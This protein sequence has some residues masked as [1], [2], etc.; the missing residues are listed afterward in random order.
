LPR[1][2]G[3]ARALGPGIVWLALAQGSG[4]LI[5]WPYVV[6]RYGLAFLF[7]LI[8]ACLV[9]WPVNYAIGRY[10][11]LT[12]ESIMRGFL[13]LDRRLGIV[14]Y[15]LMT[16]SF[17]WVGSFAAAGG[18]ALASLV[19]WPA[20]WGAKARTDLWALV[21]MALL[22]GSFLLS[23]AFY[24][25]IEWFMAAVSIVTL[26][27]LLLAC[28]HPSVLA[29]L[30]AFLRG[31]VR[32]DLPPPRPWDPG[33]ATRLLTAIT[34]A[35]LGG[36]WTLFYSYWL[37]AKGA[38]MA[39][40]HEAAAPAA[41]T[42][43]SAAQE[44]PLLPEGAMSD[45]PLWKRYLLCDSGIGVVGN[46]ATTLMTCLLAYALLFP[47]GLYPDGYRLAVVQSE[48]FAVRFGGLGR[49]LFLVVAAAFLCDTWIG[50]MDTMSR[51]H[52]DAVRA[53]VPRL[54]A[55]PARRLYY[56]FLGVGSALTVVTLPLAEPGRLIL[57]TAVI[58]FIGTVIYTWALVPL[59]GS[60][61][62]RVAPHLGP[63]RWYS[64]LALIVAAS[65]YTLL[66][67]L[68]LAALLRRG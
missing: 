53:L 4:E 42:G 56:L 33:D 31:L 8:P 7:L 30:P 35:G 62:A 6:A 3:Y 13:R 26:L 10:T 24:R 40:H 5:W 28:A 41:D 16:V 47:R 25:F 29:A 17:L 20:G 67:L 21:S 27:G 66:A 9:Q 48:F 2:P 36:F 11:I 57:M 49:I 51:V 15:I 61:L 12:G 58:G 65:A 37:R 68:Y 34:F 60:Y 18:T 14:L 23:R 38:G 50:T 64:R 63:P 46:L 22:L 44:E 59:N 52:A 43:S 1:F 19:D 55:V 54:A 39:G 45:L 32:P